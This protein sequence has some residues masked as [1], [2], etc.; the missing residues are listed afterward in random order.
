MLPSATAPVSTGTGVPGVESI[1]SE[2]PA[3]PLAVSSA[4]LAL[5]VFGGSGMA[6]VVS[7]GS[8]AHPGVSLVEV[9]V[10]DS[11]RWVPNHPL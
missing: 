11:T 3:V 9:I 6:D 4:V 2:V 10:A 7:T 8:S 5:T 1:A